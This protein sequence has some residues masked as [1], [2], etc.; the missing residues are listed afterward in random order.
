MGDSRRF[1]LFAQKIKERLNPDFEIA[2]I[3]GGKGTL[4]LALADYG[5]K[6]VE[7]WDKRH[8][9]LKGKQRFAYF[10]YKS[11]PE[12]KAVVAMHP[13]EG[14]D[15]AILYAAKHSVPACVCPCCAKG[16]A[17]VYWGANSYKN[18]VKHLLKLAEENGLKYQH[19]VMKFNGRNDFFYFTPK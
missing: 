18:W 17:V 3:A 16:S 7:T 2:D 11:A 8:R 15:H 4:R 9:H 14:T 13:D 19:E 1:N 12:Y 5:F 10:D 6:N